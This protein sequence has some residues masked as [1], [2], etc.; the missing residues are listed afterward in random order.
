M[1]VGEIHA[2]ADILTS[3][4]G[5]MRVMAYGARSRGG[6][7]RGRV[8]PFARGT[9]FLYT[10]PRRETSKVTDFDVSRYSPVMQQD[11]VAYY[12]GSLWAEVVWRTHASGDIGSAVYDL[13]YRGLDLL[14]EDISGT[15]QERRSRVQL[16]SAILLWR[17][18]ALLGLQPDMNAC[19][20][21]DR[22]LAVAE[23]RFYN[24]REGMVVGAEWADAGMVGVP[25]GTARLLNATREME[26][27][28][29]VELPVT[30]ETL[31]ATRVF[32]LSAIQD[33]VEV[34]LNTL[35]VAPQYL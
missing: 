34:P 28:R 35:R 21:T 19:G 22:P 13:L 5:M 24:R 27:A 14:E 9:I 31:A 30:P 33:A 32:V 17:Y 12:H 1:P 2:S 25:R 23:D 18:L 16:L 29:V 3:E 8:V 15:G 10:E 6:S 20:A 11:L 4:Q 26:L 7:L